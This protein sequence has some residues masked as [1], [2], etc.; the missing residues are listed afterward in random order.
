MDKKYFT[1]DCEIAAALAASG[2]K[3][4]P[5]LNDDGRVHFE[6]SYDDVSYDVDR[7]W[8]NSFIIDAKT[9]MGALA[10]VKKDINKIKF[11]R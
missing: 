1:Y 3:Y 4:I 11:S 8:S 5:F 10:M 6:F 9:L 7:Y 2:H